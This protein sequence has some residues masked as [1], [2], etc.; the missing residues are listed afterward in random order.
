MVKWHGAKQK[1]E[2][3]NKN[4]IEKNETNSWRE[5]N[6]IENDECELYGINVC[7]L[8]M[9]KKINKN[10]MKVNNKTDWRLFVI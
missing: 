7:A 8:Q 5:N 6:Q 3:K 2:N 1:Q 4:W 9:M 10:K